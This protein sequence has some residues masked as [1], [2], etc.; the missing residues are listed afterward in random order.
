MGMRIG[1]YCAVTD[2]A[3][4]LDCTSGESPKGGGHALGSPDRVGS[5]PMKYVVRSH[6][7]HVGLRNETPV[8]VKRTFLALAERS[9]ASLWREASIRK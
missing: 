6:K 5:W 7:H 1:G 4:V 2:E 9:F 3:K 8:S